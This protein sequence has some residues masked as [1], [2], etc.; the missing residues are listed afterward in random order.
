MPP[1]VALCSF[2]KEKLSC[3]EHS[4]GPAIRKQLELRDYVKK[5]KRQENDKVCV[6]EV[7]CWSKMFKA[8]E[9]Q[10]NRGSSLFGVSPQCCL[11]KARMFSVTHL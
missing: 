9:L 8:S 6:N 11:L 7:S 1:A 4:Q 5:M 10:R 3:N 2:L